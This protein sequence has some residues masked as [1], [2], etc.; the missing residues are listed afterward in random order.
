M[1]RSLMKNS[2]LADVLIALVGKMKAA[3]R[4]N[5]RFVMNKATLFEV[6]SS[7]DSAGRYIFDPSSAPGVPQTLMKTP[8]WKRRIYGLMRLV[9][10]RLPLAIFDVTI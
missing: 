3:Y 10:C 7:N 9:V 5:A 6:A 1:M 4:S 2:C 8:S